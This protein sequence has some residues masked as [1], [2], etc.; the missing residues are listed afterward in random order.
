VTFLL[1][2]FRQPE[3]E[4]RG[5]HQA[6]AKGCLTDADGRAAG[7]AYGVHEAQTLVRFVGPDE[8]VNFYSMEQRCRIRASSTRWS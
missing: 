6:K 3:R 8:A 4:R 7:H 5:T 2:Q 1:G